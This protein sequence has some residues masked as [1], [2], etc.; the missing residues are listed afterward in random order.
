MPARTL[1]TV[2]DR[3]PSADPYMDGATLA[4]RVEDWR[5]RGLTEDEPYARGSLYAAANAASLLPVA[6][7]WVTWR[8]QGGA[9]PFDAAEH[10]PGTTEITPN[11]EVLRC[12]LELNTI[13]AVSLR[14]DE[15]LPNA[16][17]QYQYY[18][19]WPEWRKVALDQAFFDAYTWLESGLQ[20]PF[21]VPTDP[22]VNQLPP[23]SVSDTVLLD[24]DQAWDLY[25]RTMAFSLAIEIGGFV[26]WSV[27]AYGA[28]DL[29]GLFHASAMFH[30]GTE[31]YDG[32]TNTGYWTG[33]VVP[34]FPRTTFQFFVDWDIIRSTHKGTIT[35]LLGWSGA[36]LAHYSDW[37]GDTVGK[38]PMEIAY[39]HWGYYGLGPVQRMLS[40]TVRGAMGFA[41][42]TWGCAG[43]C[44]FFRSVLRALNIPANFL[45]GWGNGIEPHLDGHTVPVFPTIGKALSHGDDVLNFTFSFVD[46]F[47][48]PPSAVSPSRLL[49]PWDTF[50]DWFYTNPDSNVGRQR[51]VEIP[52]DV[53][54]NPILDLYCDDLALGVSQA[55]S[56]VRAYFGAHYSLGELQ[57]LQLWQ[58]LAAKAALLD[59]C[60]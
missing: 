50:V 3:E 31:T 44:P 25:L 33:A 60:N 30:A 45:Q 19:F 8:A 41:H 15:I 16:Q 27:L 56:A 35:R 17:V 29:G 47:T 2:S 28:D 36:H 18:P 43:T 32:V 24:A 23:S 4:R 59:W 10:C 54:P 22:S 34:A 49:L 5:V 58:R 57:N 52:L 20:A 46:Q 1:V 14:W 48:P 12:W 6:D 13:V 9:Q 40:G 39:I 26:P 7:W 21:P 38:T 53:L 11:G 51:D 55:Q 37:L 42:W